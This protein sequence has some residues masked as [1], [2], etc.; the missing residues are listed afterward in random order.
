MLEIRI[1]VPGM[2]IAAPDP[3]RTSLG[4]S[5]TAGL[6]LAKALAR[7]GH[8]VTVYAN[9]DR[10]FHWCGVNIVPLH[11]YMSDEGA[12]SGD[13]LIIQRDPGFL[14]LPFTARRV[15][16][17]LHDQ[18]TPDMAPTIRSVLPALDRIMVETDAPYLAPVPHRG[19]RNEPAAAHRRRRGPD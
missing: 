4:G 2:P 16:L 11:V 18:P 19:Q 6:Q 5:E 15:F 1:V 8:K 3:Y 9:V 17:W 10:G 7:K 14:T 12:R 13:L